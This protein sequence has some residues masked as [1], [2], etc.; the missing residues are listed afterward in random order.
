METGVS[1]SRDF[2]VTDI[3]SVGKIFVTDK[4]NSKLELDRKGDQWIMDGK[5]IADKQFMEYLLLT[6]QKVEVKN[7]V[8]KAA[9][10]G[11]MKDIAVKGIKVELYNLQGRK[12]KDYYIGSESQ[13]GYANY[14]VLDGYNIP[15]AV[16]IPNFDGSVRERYW[17]LFKDNVISRKILSFPPNSIK[18]VQIDYPRN[19]N[20]SF[21]LR[22]QSGQQYD[23]Q[24]LNSTT[25]HIDK[26]VKRN[27]AEA[28]LFALEDVQA[29]SVFTEDKLPTDT[30]I[31]DIP[32]AKLQIVTHKSDTT[33]LTIY[34]IIMTDDERK[35]ISLQN[36]PFSYFI[37]KDNRLYYSG[38]VRPLE[39][40]F[41]GYS[42][43]Y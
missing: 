32:F 9:I 39:K 18:Y 40:I 5:Y 22:V 36:K 16:G 31:S 20:E 8:P 29:A 19:R 41:F 42:F 35:G 7:L 34:P 24:P 11:V 12:I 3:N 27:E 28:F 33:N 4:N 1:S 23:I 43:F 6:I 14:M 15:Y 30:L 17:P 38:Q 2:K 37:N 10:P 25:H 13:I 21:S 26:P